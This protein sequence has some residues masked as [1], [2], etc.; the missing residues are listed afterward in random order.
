MT[1]PKVAFLAAAAALLCGA[2]TVPPIGELE[3][4]RPR[5]CDDTRPCSQGF[6]CVGGFC[7][8]EGAECQPGTSRECGTDVGECIRGT[9]VCQDDGTWGSCDGL[10]AVEEVC[11]SKDN[12]CDGTTDEEAVTSACGLEEGV[13]AGK[14]KA[15]IA[16]SEE[17]VCT[18]LSYGGEYQPGDETACDD[19]DND[20]DG[21][22]DEGLT[23][24]CNLDVGVCAGAVQS[25]V[26]GTFPG[27]TAADYEAVNSAYEPFEFLCDGLD[28]DCDGSIDK[29]DVLLISDADAGSVS[30]GAVAAVVL[31]GG[32]ADG[33]APDTLTFYEEDTRVVMR[34]VFANGGLNGPILPAASVGL[35]AAKSYLPTLASDG[36]DVIAAWFD[37]LP[38]QGGGT[39]YRL[40]LGNP[41]P[42]G[43][44]YVGMAPGATPVA[45]LNSPGLAL[46]MDAAAGR[47]AIAWEFEQAGLR[48]IA[49]ANCPITLSASCQTV[50]LAQT[51]LSRPRIALLPDGS[52]MYVAYELLFD[53]SSSLVRVTSDPQLTA[54]TPIG[55][56][57]PGAGMPS[58]HADNNTLSLY[59]LNSGGERLQ[60]RSCAEPCSAQVLSGTTTVFQLTEPI[61]EY[62]VEPKGAS[63]VY[64]FT[65]AGGGV[66]W[67][68]EGMITSTTDVSS[69]ARGGV[70]VI[71]VPG[72]QTVDLYY[73]SM[74]ATSS[75][76][77]DAR[78]FCLP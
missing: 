15:C 60:T 73:E 78:R 17:A 53:G 3:A 41:R 22:T 62:A 38:L 18:I 21:Q 9:E 24:A 25:C 12:D 77:I 55:I 42:N 70:A 74:V 23:Q 65:T 43:E 39:S 36:T 33:G 75:S 57:G 69:T 26:G 34:Q 63:T 4:E 68:A 14:S 32:A 49:V 67:K 8:A 45:Q 54:G 35:V 16:G 47:V 72:A 28:N 31:P 64:V 29:W 19:K 48:R 13:C 44:T 76:T 30:R 2:C 7:S 11:D 71:P 1:S 37:E 59:F 56:S 66:Q 50:T 20:C 61:L 58:V 46:D 27:C 52:T 10:G 51:N 6:T 5:R 40:L